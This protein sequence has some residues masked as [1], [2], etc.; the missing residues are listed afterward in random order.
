MEFKGLIP[1]LSLNL[2]TWTEI[3]S[4]HVPSAILQLLRAA[5]SNRRQGTEIGS[6]NMN[7]MF[8]YLHC[9]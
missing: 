7:R 8:T 6:L 4:L 9:P 5:D 3:T 1:L 2:Q